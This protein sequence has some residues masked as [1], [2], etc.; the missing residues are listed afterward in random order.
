[1]PKYHI[2]G[3]RLVE[4]SDFKE[5]KQ[6]LARAKWLVIYLQTNDRA[7]AG[8]ASG[9]SAHAYSR[10]LDILCQNGHLEGRDRRGHPPVYHDGILEQAY[11]IVCSDT[12]GK[13]TGKSLVKD[14]KH[15]GVLHQSADVKRFL[16]RFKAYVM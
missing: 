12:S 10:I 16:A 5:Q 2:N 14:L 4:A 1:M 7:A 9:L 15:D 11:N 8:R 3:V 6:A 13:L